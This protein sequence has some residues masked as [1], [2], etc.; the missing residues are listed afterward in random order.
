MKWSAPCLA[1]RM[2]Q[3]NLIACCGICRH[4]P[5]CLVAIAGGARETEILEARFPA[6]RAGHNVFYLKDRDGQ[7]FGGS[8]IG[9]TITILIANSPLKVDRNVGAHVGLTALL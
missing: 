3:F 8:A 6:G 4:S 1:L 2:E 9:A 5:I 7:G